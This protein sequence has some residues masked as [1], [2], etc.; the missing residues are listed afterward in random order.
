LPLR[1]QPVKSAHWVQDVGTWL[2]IAM[3]HRQ[4]LYDA[5]RA[6]WAD[7]KMHGPLRIALDAVVCALA[8]GENCI[9]GVRR[10]MT[11]SGDALVRAN[12]AP[13]ATWVRR[14]L[15][16]FAVDKRAARLQS[17]SER[18]TISPA[19]TSPLGSF[20]TPP[21]G[22]D[23]LRRPGLEAVRGRAVLFG[24]CFGSP[25]RSLHRSICTQPAP[26][27]RYAADSSSPAARR[28]T[29]LFQ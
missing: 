19:P 23:A 1:T 4:G 3:L 6:S 10:L 12:R 22:P 28:S 21:F 25:G 13:S 7:E 18:S 17:V 15:G 5:A 16:S 24:S 11:T 27:P 14:V 2:L 26:P 9:E 8:L 20:R 29:R